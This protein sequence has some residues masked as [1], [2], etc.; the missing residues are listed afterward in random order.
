MKNRT[1]AIEAAPEAM[2]PNPNK[3]A[4]KAITRKT[5]AQYN[6]THPFKFYIQLLCI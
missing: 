4:T 1:F 6:I 5:A 2:P 3:A